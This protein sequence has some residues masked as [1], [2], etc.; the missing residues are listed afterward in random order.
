MNPNDLDVLFLDGARLPMQ[1]ALLEPFFRKHAS[2]RPAGAGRGYWATYFI[3]D[4]ELLVKDIEVADARN[5]R[6]GR[7]SVINEIIPEA[8]DRV[9]RWHSGLLL[10]PH[11]KGFVLV[12]IRRG[13]LRG[14][15]RMDAAQLQAFRNDQ[16]EYFCLTDDYEALRAEAQKAFELREQEARRKDAGRGYRAFDEAAFNKEVLAAILVHSKEILAD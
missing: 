4:D 9:V 8:E 1:D 10:M 15:R 6:T 3:E 13:R 16:F 5:L 2:L 14:I 7:R 12:E 11:E